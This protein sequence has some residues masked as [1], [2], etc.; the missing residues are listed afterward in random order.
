MSE[1]APLDPAAMERLCRLGGK[2]FACE[3][4][5]LFLDYVGTKVAEAR[6]AATAGDLSRLQKAVHPI[7]SSAGNVGATRLQELAKRLENEAYTGQAQM[8]AASLNTLEQAF[9]DARIELTAAKEKLADP[10][11]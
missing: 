6:Q 11:A 8:A 5:D 10:M 7:K 2:K 3:M 4:I 9:A 1:S